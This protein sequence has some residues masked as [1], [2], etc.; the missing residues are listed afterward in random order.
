MRPGGCFC[1]AIYNQQPVW[2]RFY[3]AVKRTYAASPRP[4]QHLFVAGYA[5]E[6]V[7]RGL[8]KDLLTLRNP[9]RRYQA[10]VGARGMSV[11]YD[12]VDWIGGYPFEAAT[13]EA[14]FEFV[15]QRGYS[16]EYLVT[17]GSGQGCN[18]F[19]FRRG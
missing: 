9:L 7:V 3:T 10:K 15:R 16:L 17:C 19:V 14:V 8:A 5:I 6:Q 13:P 11:W 1:I 4:V 12:W 2:T 18:E